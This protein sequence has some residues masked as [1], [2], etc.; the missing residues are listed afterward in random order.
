MGWRAMVRKAIGDRVYRMMG[1]M[2][3]QGSK[4]SRATATGWQARGQRD[5]RLGGYGSVSHRSG[6]AIGR[7][8]IGPAG[9]RVSRL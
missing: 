3:Q 6:A 2:G 4:V 8:A 7:W 5:Y 9:L 1:Y